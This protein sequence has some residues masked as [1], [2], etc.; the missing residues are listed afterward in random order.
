[1]TVMT[2]FPPA[3]EGWFKSSFSDSA[4]AC[5][6]VR[7]QEGLAYVR[8][9][10][11]RTGPMVTFNRAEWRRSSSGRGTASSTCPLDVAGCR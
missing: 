8:N 1:M 3:D 7:F 10:R 6:E 9:T 4:E 2:V 5:V 11:S